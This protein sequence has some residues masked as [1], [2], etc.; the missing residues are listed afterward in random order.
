LHIHGTKD[1]LVP[2]NGPDKKTDVAKI[3]RFRSVDDTIA[4]CIKANGC[5]ATPEVSEIEP[6]IDKIQVTRKIYNSGKNGS[7][8][9]LY[10]LQDGGHV[11]PGAL[12]QVPAFLGPST[13]NISANDVIWDFFKKH[14]LK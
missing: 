2:Y 10:V 12:L 3:L 8:V 7:E 6:K 5:S 4:A 1:T 14:S 11:W 13:R 9:V